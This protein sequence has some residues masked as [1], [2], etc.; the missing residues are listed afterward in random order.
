[1]LPVTTAKTVTTAKPKMELILPPPRAIFKVYRVSD[2]PYAEFGVLPR[3]FKL[4]DGKYVVSYFGFPTFSK[5]KLGKLDVFSAI[6]KINKETEI[7]YTAGRVPMFS[8]HIPGGGWGYYDVFEGIVTVYSALAPDEA[9]FN[10]IKVALAY[11]VVNRHDDSYEAPF[12]NY[13]LETVPVSFDPSRFLLH[14]DVTSI[15]PATTMDIKT[16]HKTFDIDPQPIIDRWD[17]SYLTAGA[18]ALT[19]T[20]DLFNFVVKDPGRVLRLFYGKF[21][22]FLGPPYYPYGFGL[23]FVENGVVG[24]VPMTFLGL[25]VGEDQHERKMKE[26]MPMLLVQL[27]D[28]LSQ[29]GIHVP[30]TD[31]LKQIYAP[32]DT[33]KYL[34]E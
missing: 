34:K 18:P 20:D 21:N 4:T 11:E 1:V 27:V 7:K 5:F 26:H 17:T 24:E 33:T 32:Y 25:L 8:D 16:K 13:D 30:L 14:V 12:T 19:S 6:S 29:M 10:I 22:L 3:S 23:R 28:H 31:D 9:T 2:K 15:K